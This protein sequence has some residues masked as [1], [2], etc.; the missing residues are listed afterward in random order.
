MVF[1]S[2]VWL[3]IDYREADTPPLLF[4]T[5]VFKRSPLTGRWGDE[6]DMKRYTTEKDA[7][8]GHRVIVSYWND[9]WWVLGFLEGRLERE[10]K[11]LWRK[12][13]K[14]I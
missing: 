3:G 5:M 13:K 1:V 14:I 12:L 9:P 11:R 2:T 6:L 7:I 10:T 4:E 8:W